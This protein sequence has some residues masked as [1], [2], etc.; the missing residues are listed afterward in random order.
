MLELD[1]LTAGYSSLAVVREV[2]LSVNAGEI[3]ALIG[4]NGA[5]K[6][7]TLAAISNLVDH[8]SGAVT[9]CGERIDLIAPAGLILRRLVHVPERRHLFPT[10]TV[11]ENL[12]LGSYRFADKQKSGRLDRIYDLFPRLS[13][14]TRQAAGT[15][16][17][18]EQQMVAIG[19]ALM[20]DPLLLMLDEPSQGLAPK[21]GGELFRV[22]AR[23]NQSGV[24]ILLVEQNA[25]RALKIAHRGY[26]LEN[27]RI[28]LQGTASD[29][30]NDDG[31]RRSYLG[32]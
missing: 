20:A 16:S 7:T 24:A 23:I 32:M 29:L 14:R 28:S 27:G 12:E 6:S 25:K 2:S 4:A 22:I 26:V 15:L 13:E 8:H 18:G 19:R 11:G 5:G 31:V 1:R 9:F 3:V 10:M 17:G 21:V 30:A